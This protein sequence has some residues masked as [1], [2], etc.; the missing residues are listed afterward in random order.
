MQFL[1]QRG[2]PII[3]ERHRKYNMVISLNASRPVILLVEDHIVLRRALAE[4]LGSVFSGCTFL[5]AGS[6]EEAVVL[7]SAN[8]P[9]IV[10]MDIQLPQINGIEAIDLIKKISPQTQAVVLSVYGSH[11]DIAKAAAV[12]AYAFINKQQMHT[13]L[14]PVLIELLGATAASGKES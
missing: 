9:D 4:W 10:L 11:F 6:G 14:I 2:S 12:G 1:I 7:A 8:H 13:D 3:L 5:A